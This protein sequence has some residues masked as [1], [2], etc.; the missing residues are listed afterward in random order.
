MFISYLGEEGPKELIG[1]PFMDN[2]SGVTSNSGAKQSCLA[3]IKFDE[4]DFLKRRPDSECIERA[5]NYDLTVQPMHV[6]PCACEGIDVPMVQ[7]GLLGENG[8]VCLAVLSQDIQL[9]YCV[10]CDVVV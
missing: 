9:L 2:D 4:V 6:L 7:R 8:G 5:A 3:W 10:G 1:I